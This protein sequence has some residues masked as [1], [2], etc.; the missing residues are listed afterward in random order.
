MHLSIFPDL[1]T[2]GLVAPLLLRL[3]VGGLILFFG[4][5]RYKKSKTIL[6]I[7]YWLVGALLVVG[8]Y[9]QVIALLGFVINKIEVY[10]KWKHRTLTAEGFA[11]YALAG[12]IFLSLLFTG[13]GF[14]AFD[15][16][17]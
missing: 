11:P 12:L 1:L 4:W 16:P 14:F 7:I 15:L 6:A 2:Y 8:L 10:P 9:T 13:P 3:G 17:L 5:Q